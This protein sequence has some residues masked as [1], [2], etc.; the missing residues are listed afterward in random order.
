ME[1]QW[2]S[3]KVHPVYLL[4]LWIREEHNCSGVIHGTQDTPL[5]DYVEEPEIIKTQSTEVGAV[6]GATNSSKG[7][8]EAV[9]D[10]VKDAVK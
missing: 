8:M 7:L 6:S 2:R 9:K 5:V 1:E 10:A 3:D 4:K